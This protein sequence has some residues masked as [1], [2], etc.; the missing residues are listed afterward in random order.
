M[1][2]DL[3]ALDKH[4]RHWREQGLVDADLEAHLRRSSEELDRSAVGGVRIED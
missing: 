2:R 3:K 4:L 1:S